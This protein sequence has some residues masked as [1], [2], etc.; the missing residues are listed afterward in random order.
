MEIMNHSLNGHFMVN[1]LVDISSPVHFLTNFLFKEAID[2]GGRRCLQKGEITQTFN[3]VVPI[4]VVT[5][6]PCFP[7]KEPSRHNWRLTAGVV[8]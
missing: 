7:S 3:A 6:S 8:K 4:I 5:P 1:P 2:W